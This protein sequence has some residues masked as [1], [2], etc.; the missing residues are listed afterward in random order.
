MLNKYMKK[1]PSAYVIR[2]IQIKTMK[3]PSM[4][5]RMAN[6]EHQQRQMLART[7]SIRNSRPLVMGMKNDT[8]SVQTV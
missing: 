5:R 2:E 8:G 1:C 3:Y 6:P 4:P 7:W